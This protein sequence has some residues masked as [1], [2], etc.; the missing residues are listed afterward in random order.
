MGL[1]PTRSY[2]DLLGDG[3]EALLGAGAQ[4]LESFAD[5][6]AARGVHGPRGERWTD[7]LLESELSRLAGEDGVGLSQE[8]P[9]TPRVASEPFPPAPK[10][11]Q[12]LLET[13]LLNLWY[14][15]ARGSDV[16]DRPLA[17]RRLARNLVLWRGAGGAVN[18]VED[19]CPHRGAPLSMGRIANGNVACPYHGVEVAGDGTVAAVPPTPDCPLVGQKAVRSYPCREFAGAVWVYFGDERHERAPEPVFPEEIASDEWTSFLYTGTWRCN[20]QLALDNRTDPVHGS[21]LHSDTFTLSY[22][23]KDAALRVEQTPT[24]FETYRTNQRDVNIDWHE[25]LIHPD[26][27]YWVRTE[28]PYPPSFGGGSF[29]ILGYLTPI[30]RDSTYFWVYRARKLTG[31]RRAMWRFLY[32]NRLEARANY[33]LG[34]DRA[35]LEAIPLAARERENLIQTDTAMARMRRHLRTEAQRQLDQASRLHPAAQ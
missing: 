22:G 10:T 23:R 29:R 27:I 24:G 28:I 12:A 32:R 6:L 3:L 26:N 8:S 16:G 9:A 13:G 2:E 34:Q 7:A 5:G 18:A 31:W 11:A 19:Y 17:V 35:L 1:T 4:T 20:W 33:V 30:D 21:F 14:L 25:V 15:V